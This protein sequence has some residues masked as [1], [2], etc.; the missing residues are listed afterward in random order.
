MEGRSTTVDSVE[1]VVIFN[2]K[3]RNSPKP[4]WRLQKKSCLRWETALE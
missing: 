4:F 1:G 2:G 3:N